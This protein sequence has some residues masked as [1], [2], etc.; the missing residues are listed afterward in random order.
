MNTHRRPHR[1]TQRFPQRRVWLA[2][3][4]VILLLV[5]VLLVQGI[6]VGIQ[7]R[8]AYEQGKQ[9]AYFMRGDLTPER[10]AL[11]KS[12]LDESAT[13]FA[14][15]EANFAPFVPLLN[16]LGWVPWIGEDLTAIPILFRAG[17]DLAN[18]GVQGFQVAEP[19]LLAPQGTSP[20]TQL[21]V[22]FQESQ[23]EVAAISAAAAAIDTNLRQVHLEQL[24]PLLRDT[25][26]GLQA[27]VAMIAPG[28]R[29]STFL[30]SLMGVGQTR[31]YLVLA[32]N[33]HELRG[34]GGF[35]TAI[36]RITMADG[37]VVG[38]EFVDSYDPSFNRTD[39][40]LPQAP[41]PMQQYMGIEVML[42][43]DVNWSPDFPTTAQIARTIYN[44]QTGRTVDG[45]ITIDLQAV[46][47]IVTALEPLKLAGID[48]PMT[49]ATVV[50]QIRAFWA[51]PPDS[52]A[53][54]ASGD[55][56]WWAQRKD[57][58]PKLAESAV[59]RIQRGDFDYLRML[60]AIQ[61]SLTNR[62]IQLWFA[63]PALAGEVAKLDWDGGLRVP[64]EGDFLALVDTNFGYNKV[65]AVI[66][67][68][69]N[70]SVEWPTSSADQRGLA[71]LAIQYRHPIARD[72]YV[73]DQTPHYDGSYEEMMVRCYF[74]YLRIYTPAGSELVGIEGV[75]AESVYNQRGEAGAQ[76]IGG[77]F[78]LSPGAT[79]TVRL[80]YHLPASITQ[81]NYQLTVRR[82]AGT[83]ALALVAHVGQQVLD[84]TLSAGLL[85]WQ[86]GTGSQVVAVA[87]P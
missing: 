32:Q 57:F 25:V 65:N 87:Q 54:L 21:P 3:S 86:P 8:N 71:T 33:N 35:V 19:I 6:R 23:A 67:Q 16:R 77:Y 5:G 79:T 9:F 66:Q 39:L 81:E 45:V 80:Q 68:S 29:L 13:A 44:Q 38:M 41:A 12:L 85:H 2:I 43:R 50:E 18:L 15:A 53:T 10:Y 64:R 69:V 70:Y 62:A 82:Q 59:A 30:P 83:P 75:L 55:P 63:D 24:S 73:C 22:T 36:G 1:S 17:H 4:V 27:A 37:R 31:T 78:I 56:G 42:L 11:A 40:P 51:A 7:L 76:V 48:Q 14:S 84:T 46:E 60:S 20:L 61:T 74:D 28:L 58:I 26:G 34:T 72:G 52:T 49:G 47:H